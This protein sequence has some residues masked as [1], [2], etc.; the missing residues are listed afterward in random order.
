[1]TGNQSNFRSVQKGSNNNADA[2]GIT[3]CFTNSL[4]FMP[5]STLSMVSVC[6]ALSAKSFHNCIFQFPHPLPYRS[7]FTSAV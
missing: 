5:F 4:T 2:T 3:V 1:M 6:H 7:W